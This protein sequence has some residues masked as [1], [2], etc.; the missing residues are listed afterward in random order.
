MSRTPT[1][2]TTVNLLALASHPVYNQLMNRVVHFEIHAKDLDAAQKFYGGIFGWTITDLG[3]QM[4]N[5]RMVSTGTDQPGA[6]WPGI[7]GGM[8]QRQG[9]P[10][11]GGE[12]VNA[13]VC[14][15]SVDHIDATPP[16]TMCHADLYYS[17]RRD[18]AGIGQ[19]LSFVVAGTAPEKDV[20]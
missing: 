16:C 13:F 17:F 2:H 3:P 9:P 15:I 12:P 8:M 1:P 20:S 4:G 7:S 18:G 10:P 11:V 19:M 14:T 6:K 5:Y